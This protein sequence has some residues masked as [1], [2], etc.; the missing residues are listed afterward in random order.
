MI[1]LTDRPDGAKISFIKKLC[2]STKI[3]RHPF[4]CPSTAR[5]EG[6]LQLGAEHFGVADRE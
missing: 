3:V 4:L 6:F 1:L 5:G 2:I